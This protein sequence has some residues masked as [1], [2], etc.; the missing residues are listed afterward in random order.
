MSV[1]NAH[2]QKKVDRLLGI[3]E[4]FYLGFPTVKVNQV[5]QHKLCDGIT[6]IVR[7][8]KPDILYTHFR[9]DINGDHREINNATLVAAR[10]YNST[11]SKILAYE[12]PSSTDCGVIP[13]TPD[14]YRDITDAIDKKVKAFSYYTTEVQKPPHSRS[15]E[16]VRVLARQRGFE[17]NKQYAEAFVLI[18]EL[19]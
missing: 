9:G 1:K 14:V 8:V 3:K 6:K 10:P 17:S 12:A 11:V 4:H 16:G 18:R 7:T 19:L 2:K 15:L 13:F 5:P